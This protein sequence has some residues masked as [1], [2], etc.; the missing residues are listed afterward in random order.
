MARALVQAGLEGSDPRCKGLDLLYLL[1]GNR[2]QM[3]DQWPHDEGRLLPVSR[4]Q[5]QP[6][7]HRD[8]RDHDLPLCATHLAASSVIDAAGIENN[9]E[10]CQPKLGSRT[11]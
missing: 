9:P 10:K 1:L 4:I 5:R 11:S 8:G 6:F 2:E 3:H 7:W